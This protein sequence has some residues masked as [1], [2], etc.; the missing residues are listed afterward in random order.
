MLQRTCGTPERRAWSESAVGWTNCEA[1]FR[2]WFRE[3]NT[4]KVIGPCF[5]KRGQ[6]S[7][8]H[9]FDS[10][11]SCFDKGGNVASHVATFEGP[12]EKR[13]CTFLPTTHVLVRRETEFK[14]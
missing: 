9:P 8:L 13:F 11:S 3:C 14:K 12:L 1:S 7:R 6:V 2:S 10:K 5:W 4:P